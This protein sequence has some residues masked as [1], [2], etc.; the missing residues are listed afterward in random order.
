MG[1]PRQG[2]AMPTNG[3]SDHCAKRDAMLGRNAMPNAM[4]VDAQ[5][6]SVRH[7]D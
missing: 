4:S 3:V 2:S 6:S 1:A 7:R 5:Q